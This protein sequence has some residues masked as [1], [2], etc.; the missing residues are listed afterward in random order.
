MSFLIYYETFLL[1]IPLL[2]AKVAAGL[3][4]QSDS[5]RESMI[6]KAIFK[7]GWAPRDVIQY[8]QGK[9][10][11]LE[12]ALG[13]A[14]SS[15]TSSRLFNRLQHGDY[16]NDDML[17]HVIVSSYQSSAMD[18]ELPVLD[19]RSPYIAHRVQ[20]RLDILRQD[21]LSRFIRHCRAHRESILL[22]GWAF[23]NLII[24]ILSNVGREDV[25]SPPIPGTCVAPSTWSTTISLNT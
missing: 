8:L 1:L 16:D 11:A 24:D 7:W 12:G 19:L 13:K 21:E 2:S 14:L 15:L 18:P 23:E 20:R 25:L 17:S 6:D 22:A 4:E 5:E 9:D 10:R 3:Q